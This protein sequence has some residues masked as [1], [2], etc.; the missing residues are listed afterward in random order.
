[1][2][3]AKFILFPFWVQINLTRENALQRKWNLVGDSLAYEWNL[4][5]IE[6][7]EFGMDHAK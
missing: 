7:R 6:C 1:M 5:D 3:H 4:N 2:S